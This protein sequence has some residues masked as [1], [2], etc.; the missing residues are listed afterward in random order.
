MRVGGVLAIAALFAAAGVTA[1][2]DA[3]ELATEQQRLVAAKRDAALAAARAAKLAAAATQERNAA[4][5]ARREE[6][7]LAARVTA[8]EANLATASARVTLVERLLSDQRAKLGRAQAPVARLLAALES[9]A[10]RPTIVAVAQPGSVDDLVHVRAVLGSALPVVRQRTE[11][12]RTELAETRR[13]QTSAT[14]AAKALSDGRARLESD[15][16]ALATL[17][18]RHRQRSRSLGRGALSESDRALALGERAR[19]L[20]DGMAAT[21]NAKATAASLI[22]LAGPIPRPIAPGTTRPAPLRGVYRTPVAG[23]LVTGFD[24]VS[25]S[26]V[27]SRGLTFA[28]APRARVVAP[29]AGTVRYA[30][31]FRDYGT[32][33]I[34]DHADGWTTLVTGLASTIAKPG[35]R[36]T[37]GT[38]IGTAPSEDPRI[39][40]E[41]RRRGRPVDVAA[42]IGSR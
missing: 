16:I 5:K 39:T 28:T 12:V 15:R 32:I 24:E 27:R 8:A 25:D 2:T 11:A 26:G 36:V 33:V 29:A 23:R 35:N 42:L 34:I 6:Q 1:Q 10:R 38:T 4:D 17:E 30:R 41:L 18:A 37:M 7:A 13:L 3:P 9:L 40:V 19:D 22:A 14:L 31:R 20:V 21:T